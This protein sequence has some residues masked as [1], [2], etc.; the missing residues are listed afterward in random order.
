[1]NVLQLYYSYATMFV[2]YNVKVSVLIFESASQG[3]D[4]PDNVH[5][6]LLVWLD[7]IK[8]RKLI[9]TEIYFIFQLFF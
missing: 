3:I 8:E 5:R 2:F 1:M 7:S 4:A 6:N 9:Y